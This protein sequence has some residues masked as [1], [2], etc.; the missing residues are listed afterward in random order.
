MPRIIMLICFLLG[1]FLLFPWCLCCVPFCMDSCLDVIHSCPSCNRILGRFSRVWKDFLNF[2][3][4]I[5][6]PSDTSFLY[7]ALGLSLVR[8]L[9]LMYRFQRHLFC[10]TADLSWCL[11]HYTWAKCLAKVFAGNGGTVDLMYP[12]F[13]LLSFWVR[14]VPYPYFCRP[15][16]VGYI[17]LCRQ[18]WTR[19]RA[20]DGSVQRVSDVLGSSPY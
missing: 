17:V 13:P 8:K 15:G 12:I 6:W 5:H 1:F 3:E 7:C 16:L 14:T 10:V 19:C 2:F 20:H 11:L 4:C 9:N 18:K